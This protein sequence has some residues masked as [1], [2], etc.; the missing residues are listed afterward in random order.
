M[1]KR[2]TMTHTL[3]PKKLDHGRL[4]CSAHVWRI[5]RPG[6]LWHVMACDGY[7]Y[8]KKN[9]SNETRCLLRARARSEDSFFRETSWLKMEGKSWSPTSPEE[10]I[11]ALLYGLLL[12]VP[13]FVYSSWSSWNTKHVITSCRSQWPLPFVP[14]AKAGEG[15]GFRGGDLGTDSGSEW[16]KLQVKMHQTLD[17]RHEFKSHALKNPGALGGRDKFSTLLCFFTPWRE[18]LFSEANAP[19]VPCGIQRVQHWH[20]MLKQT[21]PE[22][23]PFQPQESGTW[24]TFPP[25]WTAKNW[26]T[27]SLAGPASSAGLHRAL[28]QGHCRLVG[29]PD[30]DRDR[31]HGCRDRLTGR[32][33]SICDGVE[34]QTVMGLEDHA[35]TWICDINCLDVGEK[36][37][38][39]IYVYRSVSWMVW[40]IVSF[41]FC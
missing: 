35:D 6:D 24:F 41:K 18:G 15:E 39:Y 38:I 4:W 27:E 12:A 10:K 40:G 8:A 25:S 14:V 3:L 31:D 5:F 21:S 9:A 32:P 36:K 2:P 34:E 20:A 17:E 7:D 37:Y 30:W 29:R 16:R 23:V 1:G 26:S 19:N 22:H 13:L 33:R 11:N 28:S